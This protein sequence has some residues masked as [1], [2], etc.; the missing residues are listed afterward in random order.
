MIKKFLVLLFAV[1]TFAFGQSSCNGHFINLLNEVCWDCVFP[2]TLGGISM[3][4][5]FS[6]SGDYDSGASKSP[7]CFCANSLMVGTPMSLWEPAM[8]F[9]VTDKAGCMPLLGTSIT[10]PINTNEYGSV[11]NSQKP[12]KGS[13]RT[14]FMHVNEYIN[15][16]LTT[17]GLLYDSPCLDNRSYD[18]PYMS[19]ADPSYSDDSMSLLLTPWAYPFTSILAV[20]AEGPDAI[21]ANINFPL[22]SLFWVAGSWGAIYP[23]TGNVATYHSQEQ[24]NHLLI[25]R[26]LAKLHA[27]GLQQS[28]AGQSALASCGALGVP[29][30]IMDKRQYKISRSLPYM[31]NMCMPIGR[32][33]ILEESGTSRPQ[34]KDY[35]YIVFR[36]KDCCAGYA[37]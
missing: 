24:T 7:I 33:T 12:I 35:G 37:P 31:D 21:A 29:E 5:G 8:M 11:T 27:T 30:F 34:D 19:W 10:T 1:P 23:T 20:A 32:S 3:N 16:I 22:A 14:A 9:D 26:L 18:I 4:F 17:I 2:M 28:T 6:N 13:S 25:T 36:K 15:P